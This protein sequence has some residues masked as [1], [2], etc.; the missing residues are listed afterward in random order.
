MSVLKL[1]EIRKKPVC[2][3]VG[4][5]QGQMIMDSWQNFLSFFS[6]SEKYTDMQKRPCSLP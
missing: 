2:V 4:E 3:K 5:E 1:L 6:S